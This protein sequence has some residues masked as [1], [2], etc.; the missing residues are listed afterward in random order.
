MWG[1]DLVSR[2][3]HMQTA[4]FPTLS[5]RT[6]DEETSWFARTA[7]GLPRLACESSAP[8]SAS[9]DVAT[10]CTGAASTCEGVHATIGAGMHT[11][12]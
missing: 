6:W 4:V 2:L 3:A 5:R 1:G 9:D 8:A 10:E 7:E 12:V 11:G